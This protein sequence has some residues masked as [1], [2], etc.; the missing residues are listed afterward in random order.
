VI[1]DIYSILYSST[2]GALVAVRYSAGLAWI[3][4]YWLRGEGLVRLIEAMVYLSC[5][6]VGPIRYREQ[7]MAA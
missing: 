5:C 1:T 7:R 4:A 3:V 6:T 2:N